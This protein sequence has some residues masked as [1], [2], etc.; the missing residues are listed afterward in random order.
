MHRGRLTIIGCKSGRLFSV[1]ICRALA[2]AFRRRYP[3]AGPNPG[4]DRV[5]VS[6]T[7]KRFANGEVKVVI[8]ENIR[9]SDA[10]VVQSVCDPLSSRSVNDNLMAVLTAINAAHQSDAETITAVLPYFPYSRQE[11]K[12]TREA[13]TA[14]QIA[15]FLEASGVDRVLT[16]DIHAEAIAGF[17]R[18]ATLEDLHASRVL[19]AEF[20]EVYPNANRQATLAVVSPDV[21][22]ANRARYFSKTLG[23]TLA[24][25]DKERDYKAGSVVGTRLVGDV[26]GKDVLIVD[27]MIDQGSSMVEVITSVKEAGARE[28]YVAC[29]FALLNGPAIGLFDLLYAQADL[30]CVIGTDAVYRGRGFTTAHPWYREV[31]VAPLFAEVISRINS[32]Q[33]VSQLLK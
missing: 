28:V 3:G 8:N 17:F 24:I 26:A 19:I 25:G 22:S 30:K 27:D 33:S 29:S 16:L 31:S 20:L 5:A 7:E 2:E 1:R 11:R 23:C 14:A 15:G 9:G 21:G 10:Y 6:V 13:I 12:K 4:P 18:H 32:K